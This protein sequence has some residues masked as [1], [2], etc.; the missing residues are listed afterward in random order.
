MNAKPSYVVHA[1][2]KMPRLAIYAAYLSSERDEFRKPLVSYVR[3]WS[4]VEPMTTG[5]DLRE[6][7]LR[8][9]PAYGRI[10]TALRDA[11]LDGEVD[12]AAEEQAYL[13]E[14]IAEVE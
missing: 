12:S 9:S 7:G 1:L 3:E 6:M 13:A 14:L 5:D 4:F 8:P 2:E 10:L 11:W